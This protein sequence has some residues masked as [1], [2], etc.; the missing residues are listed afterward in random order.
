MIGV[1]RRHCNSISGTDLIRFKSS[2]SS[3]PLLSSDVPMC[4]DNCGLVIRYVEVRSW[5][6]SIGFVPPE[7][8]FVRVT[9]NGP[10]APPMLST[11][12]PLPLTPQE[13]NDA[14]EAWLLLFDEAD[15]SDALVVV[16]GPLMEDILPGDGPPPPPLPR[17]KLRD[18]EERRSLGPNMIG[19]GELEA[20][21][22]EAVSSELP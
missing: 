9:A 3:M 11:T 22:S 10:V 16:L 7:Y 8:G 15:L 4:C 14:D 21:S 18:A 6:I 13:D 1:S 17:S 19:A 20:T 12:V 5:R 2:S